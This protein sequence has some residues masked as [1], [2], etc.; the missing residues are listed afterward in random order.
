MPM[1]E[2][3]LELP[4]VSVSVDGMRDDVRGVECWGRATLQWNGTWHC[5][6]NVNGSLCIVEVKLN[7][8][9]EGGT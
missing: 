3:Q 1:M 4:K 6:A 9:S 8:E 5:Y 7:F 2:E